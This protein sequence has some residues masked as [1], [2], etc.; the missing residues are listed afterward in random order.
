MGEEETNCRER[1]GGG[2]PQVIMKVT[3][4]RHNH[5]T[6]TDA[7]CQTEKSHPKMWQKCF[8]FKKEIDVY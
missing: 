8:C 3:E 6:S 1:G 2:A 4:N 5:S 7:G